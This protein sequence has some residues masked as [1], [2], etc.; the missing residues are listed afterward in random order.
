MIGISA[1][2]VFAGVTAWWKAQ[3]DQVS[4]DESTLCPTSGPSSVTAILVDQTDPLTRIQ[5]ADLES[6]LMKV[7]T[8]IEKFGQLSLHSVAQDAE[9]PYRTHFV[10]CN[11]GSGENASSVT[12]NP[13]LKRRRWKDL[14]A[15]PVAAVLGQLLN[16]APARRSPLMESLQWLSVSYF[17]QHRSRGI[18]IKLIFASDLLQHSDA[19]SHYRARMTFSSFKKSPEY[20]LIHTDL[21]GVSVHIY[22]LRRSGRK[23]IQDNALIG[24][25]KQ[26]FESQGAAI[27]RVLRV[28]G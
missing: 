12:S 18:P 24:F 20:G 7:A 17:A 8:G 4:L 27:A 15:T 6:K 11:P 5:K 23:A 25:W 28:Q 9:K 1:L 26:Y 10:K 2:V 13:Q 19:F 22:L 14:F 16:A 3:S 21:R